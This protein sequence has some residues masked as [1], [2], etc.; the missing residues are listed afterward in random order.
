M[1]SLV[2]RHV[3]FPRVVSTLVKRMFKAHYT[4]PA[5]GLR[6]HDKDVY[7]VVKGLVRFPMPHSFI[8]LTLAT[9]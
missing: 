6:Y 2:L 5:T 8:M 3:S 4:D 7:Q 1:I 9:R